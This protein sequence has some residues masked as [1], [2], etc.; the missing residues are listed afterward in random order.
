[1]VASNAKVAKL[2]NLL[3]LVTLRLAAAGD[4]LHAERGL[5]S[6]LRSLLVSLAGHGPRTVSEMAADRRVSRQYL[7]RAVD[8]LVARGLAEPRDNP[9]H[10]RSPLIVLSK[11]GLR[12][13]E[14]IAKAEAPHAARLAAALDRTDLDA[15][16]DALETLCALLQAPEEADDAADLRRVTGKAAR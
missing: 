2:L 13:V 8:D 1:M 9:R 12:M 14:T 7:Q 15:A 4:A 3:P 5:T 6:A 16:I 11:R 10:R